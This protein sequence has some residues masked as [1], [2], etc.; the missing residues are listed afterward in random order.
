MD[1]LRGEMGASLMKSRIMETTLQYVRATMNSEFN[2]IKEMM[3]HTIR[4]KAG[5][6][7]KTVNSYLVELGLNWTDLYDMTKE[8]LKRII[9]NYDTR[10]WQNNIANKSTLKYYK[11]GKARIGYDSCYRNNASSM[12]LARA[13]I[14]S[15]KLEE[16]VGRGKNNYNSNCKLCGMEEKEDIVHFTITCPALERKRDYNLIDKKITNPIQRMV[17]LLFKNNKHQD[18]GNMLKNLWDRR[19]AI[20]KFKEEKMNRTREGKRTAS[21]IIRSDPGPAEISRVPLRRSRS[22]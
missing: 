9:K 5:G 13:R 17:T 7:Y 16:A 3:L 2:N 14:N 19:K 4:I 21:I 15:L 8:E 18:I 10:I 11:M 6:W 20:L 22:L 12:F 1:A